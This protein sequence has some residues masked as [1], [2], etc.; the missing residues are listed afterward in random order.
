MD[1]LI[2]GASGFIG[3]H[4]LSACLQRGHKVTACVRNAK[5]LQRNFPETR[6]ISCDFTQDHHVSN[7]LPRLTNIDVVINAVGIIQQ[8][9]ANTFDALH[10]QSPTALFKACEIAG[11]KKVVQIS[12]LGADD[13]AFSQYHLS[14][15]AADDALSELDL[16]WTIMMPSIVYGPGANSM[17]LFK[18]MA[19]LPITP[20]VGNGEQKI[21]PIHINDLSHATLK[22]IENNIGQRQRIELV[23]PES[24][25]L[26]QLFI[27]LKQWLGKPKAHFLHVPVRLAQIVARLIAVQN[28]S[29]INIETI[30]MLQRGNTGNVESFISTFGFS[31]T[32]LQTALFQQ[33]PLQS[34]RL[35]ANLYFLLP[36]LKITLAFL[37]ITTGLI[38][39]F[40]YPVGSSYAMLRQVGIPESLAPLTLYAAAGLDVCLGAALL[41]SFRVRLVLILQIMAILAY[42][43]FITLGLPELWFHPFGPITKNL[44]LIVTTGILLVTEK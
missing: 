23:G 13:T 36:L 27:L 11:V 44:P 5:W 41:A 8:R 38:S 35:D 4:L 24:V 28:N 25:T 6:L 20:L 12:A 22:I 2:T 7:W 9:G 3:R 33:P 19:A 10:T 17:R 39:V 32:R 1:I 29:S 31:P 14:K 40:A 18:A 30:K 21:Q 34:D 26:Q 15:K 43:I 42:T 16:N 37:W